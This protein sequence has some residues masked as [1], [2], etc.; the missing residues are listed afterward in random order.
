MKFTASFRIDPSITV[1]VVAAGL[2]VGAFGSSTPFARTIT[3]LFRAAWLYL[4]N[5]RG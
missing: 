2:F 1:S 5:T 4:S 3:A